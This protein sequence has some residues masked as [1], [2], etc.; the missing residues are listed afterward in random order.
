M[1]ASLVAA[2]LQVPLA[3]HPA[4]LVLV[5][6][7]LTAH[8]NHREPMYW[9][10]WEPLAAALDRQRPDLGWASPARER[11]AQQ[12]V[13]RAVETLLN[14]G[15]IRR[16]LDAKGTPIKARAG[17]QAEYVLLLD[18]ARREACGESIGGQR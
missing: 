10:G 9:A 16:N 12:A 17:K 2:A 4:R 5:R 3:S 1:G 18:G 13:A 6:M 14:A 8:D 15:Y 7:A 11:A